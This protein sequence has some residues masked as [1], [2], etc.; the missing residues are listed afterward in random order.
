MHALLASIDRLLVLHNGTF[1]VGGDPHAVI[2]SPEV[3]EIYMGMET[4]V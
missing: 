3:A 4:D 1:I 2:R